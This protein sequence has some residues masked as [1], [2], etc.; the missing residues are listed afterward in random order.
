MSV[1]TVDTAAQDVAPL[2]FFSTRQGR[3]SNCVLTTEVAR[4]VAEKLRRRLVLPSCH[5]SPL[6]EQAC[7]H[8][9]DIPSQRQVVVPFALQKVLQARDL[10]R[11]QHA[12]NSHGAAG[13]LTPGDIPLSAVPRNVTC[14]DIGTRSAARLVQRQARAESGR[15]SPC[16]SELLGDDE[17]RSQLP[18]RFSGTITINADAAFGTRLTF[19]GLPRP[20][21]TP[22]AVHDAAS[23]E[24]LRNGRQDLFLSNAFSLFTRQALGPMFGLCALP[25]ETEGVARMAR[26]LEVKL[27]LPR[28]STLC[29]HWRGEDFHHPAQLAKQRMPRNA[30]SGAYVAR[31]L[32]R[33][34][35][36]LGAEG[37]LLLTNARYEALSEMLGALRTSG[38]RAES[39]RV[40]RESSTFGCQSRYVYGTMAEMLTCSRM[41][42]YAG[43][44]GSSFSDH[45]AAM[46]RARGHNSSTDAPLYV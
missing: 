15:P 42:H 9:P 14:L 32:V 4:F 1:A 29:F 34:A 7:A 44:P 2:L 8:R 46:R 25:R 41:R 16:E 35:K 23:A 19:R 28:A 5:T 12:A 13:I 27:A 22:A 10:A 33:R 43:T 30:S 38:V 17:L 11:C 20:E 31:A 3:Q 21:L 45:I 18:I 26:H 6:G 40:L 24:E 36:R 37:I 39:P